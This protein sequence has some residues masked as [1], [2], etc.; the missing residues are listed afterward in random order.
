[1]SLTPQQQEQ[2]SQLN[3]VYEPFA[4]LAQ[5]SDADGELA[6]Q[7]MLLEPTPFGSVDRDTLD[8]LAERRQDILRR[9]GIRLGVEK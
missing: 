3:K 7:Q 4:H 5:A 1:M 9:K 6:V 8:E 2:L